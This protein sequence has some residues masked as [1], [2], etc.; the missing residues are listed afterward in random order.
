[1]ILIINYFGLRVY[2]EISLFDRVQFTE[3]K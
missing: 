3:N 2:V 1:M